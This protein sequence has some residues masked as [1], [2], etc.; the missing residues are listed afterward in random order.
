MVLL[1][2]YY[3]ILYRP[4]GQDGMSTWWI[5]AEDHKPLVFPRNEDIIAFW[6][7]AVGVRIEILCDKNINHRIV[8]IPT[9]IKIEK[10]KRFLEVILPHVQLQIPIMF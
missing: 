6:Q 10:R 8:A 2:K 7:Q 5:G 3:A 9:G 1:M 4:I